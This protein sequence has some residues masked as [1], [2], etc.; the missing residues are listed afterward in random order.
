V[1]P[2]S[3]VPR[4]AVGH[5]FHSVE[6]LNMV[7]L[8]GHPVIIWRIRDIP[9]TNPDFSCSQFTGKKEYNPPLVLRDSRY[10]ITNAYHCQP[11]ECRWTIM[12]LCR[13]FAKCDNRR[14][15]PTILLRIEQKR[16]KSVGIVDTESKDKMEWSGITSHSL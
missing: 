14:L 4:P 16:T 1:S 11:A 3:H 2:L 5:A 15:F 13:E 6:S 8:H 7:V 12:A 10:S 9:H